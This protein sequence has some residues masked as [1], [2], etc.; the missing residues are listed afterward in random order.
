MI[1][2]SLDPD[3]PASFFDLQVS[4]K[5]AP[6][7][8]A[9]APPNWGEQVVAHV[10]TVAGQT[11]MAGRAYLNA[12]EALLHDPRNAERMRADSGITEYTEAR[13]R[14]VAR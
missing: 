14:A 10:Q 13:Q 2:P 9:G 6:A 7:L 5:D 11:G 12:D 8:W 1:S 3:K 4:Q